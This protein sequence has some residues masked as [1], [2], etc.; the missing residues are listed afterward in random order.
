[1]FLAQKDAED[2]FGSSNIKKRRNEEKGKRRKGKKQGSLLQTCVLLS[3]RFCDS[4]CYNLLLLIFSGVTNCARRIM[5]IIL[6]NTVVP[7]FV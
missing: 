5:I 7:A 3:H 4:L 2:D 1:M 6:W